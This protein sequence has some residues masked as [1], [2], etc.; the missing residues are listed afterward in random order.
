MDRRQGVDRFDFDHYGLFDQQVE[1]KADIHSHGAIGDGHSN[2][3]LDLK[4]GL[5]QLF[6]KA[7]L[8][9]RFEKPGSQRT[10]DNESGIQDSAAH[11]LGGGGDGRGLVVS[12][13]HPWCS[14]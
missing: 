10:V 14:L 3:P 7:G 12:F 2:L 11:D 6:G 9:D 8:V 13:V 1:A 4:S 5:S